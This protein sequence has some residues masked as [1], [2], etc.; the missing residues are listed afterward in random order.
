MGLVEPTDRSE[1]GV[2]ADEAAP[3]R[4]ASPASAQPVR[5]GP[6]HKNSPAKKKSLNERQCGVAAGADLDFY[7]PPFVSSRGGDTEGVGVTPNG[8]GMSHVWLPHRPNPTCQHRVAAR[9]LPVKLPP[10][11]SQR[12]E[13]VAPPLRHFYP[14]LPVSAPSVGRP[15]LVGFAMCERPFDGIGVPLATFV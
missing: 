8:H 10:A 5:F 14:L 9:L 12:I 15:H 6:L 13:V 1:R 3:D 7:P 2:W 4:R 11:L